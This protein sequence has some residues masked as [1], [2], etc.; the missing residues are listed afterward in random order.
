MSP[1]LLAIW[2]AIVPVQTQT[3]YDT[4]NEMIRAAIDCPCE[5][6]FYRQLADIQAQIRRRNR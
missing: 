4:R 3:L 2:L 5:A 1:V 6:A